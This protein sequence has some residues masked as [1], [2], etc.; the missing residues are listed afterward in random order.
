MNNFAKIFGHNIKMESRSAEYQ[1]IMNYLKV[2]G[3]SLTELILLSDDEYI[4]AKS[5]LLERPRTVQ[6]IGILDEAREIV[7]AN[8][9]GCNII[10]C[11]IE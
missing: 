2:T 9:P 8:A 1:S 3:L 11:V 7:Q 5:K 10:R 4:T 6:F